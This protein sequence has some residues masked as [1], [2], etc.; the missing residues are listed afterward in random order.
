MI[1][2]ERELLGNF[3]YQLLQ[4]RTDAKDPEAEQMIKD[5]LSRQPDAHYLLV[6]KAIL[7]EQALKDAKSQIAALQVQARPGEAAGFLNNN[8]WGSTPN[9]TPPSGAGAAMPPSHPSAPVA[10]IPS[11]A[12]PGTGFLG[13]AAATAAGVAGGAFLFEGLSNLFGHH[14]G[15]GGFSGFGNNGNFPVDENVVVNNY[16]D[17]APNQMDTTG[18]MLDTG[19]P[20]DDD[21]SSGDDSSWI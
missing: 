12:S 20:A 6:Q 10:P 15:F 1:Q 2:H 21:F 19:Y 16:Y 7:L 17:N 3:L 13:R 18:T 11:T 9:A 5:T 14:S 4:A 8:L